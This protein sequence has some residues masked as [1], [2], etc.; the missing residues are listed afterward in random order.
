[1]KKGISFLLLA[2][3]LSLSTLTTPAMADS[4][5]LYGEWAWTAT[6]TPAD[7]PDATLFWTKGV[8]SDTIFAIS[9][10]SEYID[11]MTIKYRAQADIDFTNTQVTAYDITSGSEKTINLTN[12]KY[13]FAFKTN[14]GYS[15]L[16]SWEYRATDGF[17]RLSD[18]N[19]TIHYYTGSQDPSPV[20]VPGAAMLLG[21]G[22]L[23]L[24]SIRSRMNKLA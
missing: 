16:Y 2:G 4:S 7:E 15:E 23:G 1:M 22:L 11:L 10:G 19:Y 3:V 12:G 17:Y 8:S 14:T 5:G 21:S 13:T 24:L 20:P 6:A 9:N 18:N